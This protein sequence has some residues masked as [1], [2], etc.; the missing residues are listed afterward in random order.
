MARRLS[1]TAGADEKVALAKQHGCTH[2]INYN[3]ENFVERVRELTNGA[4][5][6]V[7]YDSIGQATC[8]GSLDCLRP[9]GLFVTFG[10]A[11]GP[12]T[13]FD[14]GSLGPKGSLYVTRPTLFTYTAQREDLVANA[15]DLFD[16]VGSGAVKIS[17][18]QTY[19]LAEA[20][21]AHQDLE[22][23]ATTGSTIFKP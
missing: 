2:G 1:G 22:S 13:N 14:L 9:F 11:S 7:V 23:R 18:N 8:A 17:V 21:K 19:P 5:V 20:A 6:D 4:G 16:V 10:N 3:S 12:I 15:N